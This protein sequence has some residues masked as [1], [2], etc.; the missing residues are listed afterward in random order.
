MHEDNEK[1]CA[2]FHS[3]LDS[4]FDDKIH[5]ILI[6]IKLQ[7]GKSEVL[8]KTKSAQSIFFFFW[9]VIFS[10]KTKWILTNFTNL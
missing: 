9:G 1:Y 6:E 2:K 5:S 3:K 7:R 10:M 8:L 4:T